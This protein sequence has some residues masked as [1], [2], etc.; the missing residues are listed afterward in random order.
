MFVNILKKYIDLIKR[1]DPREDDEIIVQRFDRFNN[2]MHA[3]EQILWQ[4][5]PSLH[6]ACVKA[7][8]AM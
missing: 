3:N 6:H 1:F 4:G 2:I 7:D 5:A 8:L